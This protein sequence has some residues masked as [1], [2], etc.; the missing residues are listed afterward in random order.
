MKM[1]TDLITL[2]EYKAYANIT[3]P[4]HDAEIISLIPKV[5]ALVKNYCAGSFVDYYDEDKVEYFNGDVG[6]FILKE[7]PVVSVSG[8]EYSSDYGQTYTSLTEFVDWVED[9]GFI[10]SIN[11]S[12]F[13]RQLRGYKVSYKAGYEV[14]PEDLK[15]AILDLVTYYR[16]ND[17]AIHSPKAP[18]TN[19]VQIEYI[20]T[21]S[22]PAHIRRVLDLYKGDFT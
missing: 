12:G 4:N 16:R 22:L 3:N 18:G 5:S 19:S 11:A 7:W 10:L 14:L 15:L 2:A 21:T 20:T 9:S 13:P 17:G 6:N 8:V 1:A